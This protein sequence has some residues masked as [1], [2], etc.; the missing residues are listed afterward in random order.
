MIGMSFFV[1]YDISGVTREWQPHFSVFRVIYCVSLSLSWLLLTGTFMSFPYSCTVALPCSFC[2]EKEDRVTKMCW[3][4]LPDWHTT[5]AGF[6]TQH[7]CL[8]GTSTQSRAAEC[9]EQSL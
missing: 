8:C 3:W 2:V 5:G 6:L 7:L 4:Y 9:A 1:V